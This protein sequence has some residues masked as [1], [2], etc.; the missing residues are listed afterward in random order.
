MPSKKRDN[1]LERFGNLLSRNALTVSE[2][3]EEED[4]FSE[5]RATT[6]R[7]ITSVDFYNRDESDND[8]NDGEQELIQIDTVELRYISFM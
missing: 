2:L 7:K 3:D 8:C 5:A 1:D 6:V 4:D